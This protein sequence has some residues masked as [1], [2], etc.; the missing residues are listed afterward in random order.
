MFVV[1]FVIY[2][3]YLAIKDA[4]KNRWLRHQSFMDGTAWYP[5]TTG[6]R[7]TLTGLPYS[8]VD[9]NG[10]PKDQRLHIPQSYLTNTNAQQT[11]QT[12]Q[13]HK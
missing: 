10:K 12:Q 1:I 8:F 11:Q 7:D 6:P 2:L 5:S 13:A 3:I 9:E 4:R